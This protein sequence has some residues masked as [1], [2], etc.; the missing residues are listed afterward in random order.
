MK[1]VHEEVNTVGVTNDDS[2]GAEYTLRL[3]ISGASANSA[4]AVLNLISVCDTYIKGRYAL[5]VIDIFQD[6]ELAHKE[7]ITAVPSLI[8]K[9]PLSAKTLVGTMSNCQKILQGLRLTT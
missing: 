7:H 5:E 6:H 9:T 1:G 8:I 4:K 3:F 2:G